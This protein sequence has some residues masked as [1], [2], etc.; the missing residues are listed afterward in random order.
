MRS[1]GRDELQG[2]LEGEAHLFDSSCLSGNECLEDSAEAEAR[3][4]TENN[5]EGV[6]GTNCCGPYFTGE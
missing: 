5:G 4:L 1:A 3:H 6:D 2:A